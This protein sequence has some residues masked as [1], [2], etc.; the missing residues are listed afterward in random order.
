MA[1]T[2]VAN[3]KMAGHTELR[4]GISN[5]LPLQTFKKEVWDQAFFNQYEDYYLGTFFDDYAG[6]GKLLTDNK[7]YWMERGKTYQQQFI[8]DADGNPIDNPSLAMIETICITW[9]TPW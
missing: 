5:Y 4:K 8:K 1:L 9:F 2:A 3:P 6:Q 7:F